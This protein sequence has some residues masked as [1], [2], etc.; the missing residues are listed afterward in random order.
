MFLVPCGRLSWLPAN[1][2]AHV[3]MS[4]RIMAYRRLYLCLRTQ[5]AG[6]RRWQQTHSWCSVSWIFSALLVVKGWLRGGNERISWRAEDAKEESQVNALGVF[7]CRWYFLCRLN[8]LDS[9]PGER[10]FYVTD[11]LWCWPYALPQFTVAMSV[12]H[13][14]QLL[15]SAAVLS[16]FING[17]V[18]LRCEAARHV[19]SFSS[20]HT[21]ICRNTPQRS[22]PHL[23]WANLTLCVRL[24]LVL[25]SC[26]LGRERVTLKLRLPRRRKSFEVDR[27]LPSCWKQ[28]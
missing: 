13:N 22:T 9:S 11:L 8:L 28:S 24:C 2:W 15:V 16:F 4:Y 6:S 10:T 7:N 25:E 3:N 5:F 27:A 12:A 26:F 19:A 21:A 23:V 1:F 18:A 14:T 20:R 17:C